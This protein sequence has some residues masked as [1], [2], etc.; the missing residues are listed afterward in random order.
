MPTLRRPQRRS[1]TARTVGDPRITSR[2]AVTCG[3]GDVTTRI[4]WGA[5]I[6]IL[7]VSAVALAGCVPSNPMP[8]PT[9]EPSSSSTAS[10]SPTSTGAAFVPNGTAE[11]NKAIFDETNSQF[12]FDHGMGDG[13][14]I[15]DNLVA[16]GFTKGDME[17]T[18]DTTALGIAVDSLIVSVRIGQDCL[19]GQF[20][21]MGYTG[22]IEPVLGTGKCLIGT[23]RTVDW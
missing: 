1:D 10:P 22:M 14:A 17:L 19:I 6:P 12:L 5:V 9:Y 23:T 21:A 4:A 3:K 13:R 16:L 20:S 7:A 18:P 11:Q 8:V 15:F 2:V